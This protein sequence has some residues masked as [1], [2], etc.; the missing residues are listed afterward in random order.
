[1]LR[2]GTRVAEMI[3]KE[4]LPDQLDDLGGT[5]RQLPYCEFDIGKNEVLYMRMSSGGGYGDPLEREPERVLN[6]VGNGIVSIAEA[7]EIY[8]VVLATNDLV[9]DLPAT[10]RE[11]ARLR[12]GRLQ[13]T[14]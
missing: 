6:D 10:E 11:R 13:E 8:G 3:E 9:L 5:A 1:V 12:Q 7:R 14:R 2:E 4:K